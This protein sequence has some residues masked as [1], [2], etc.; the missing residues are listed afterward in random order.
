MQSASRFLFIENNA[1]KLAQEVDF[2]LGQSTIELQ[3]RFFDSTEEQLFNIIIDILNMNDNN[4]F[5]YDFTNGSPTRPVKLW[6]L[7]YKFLSL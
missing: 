4:P 5:F 2:D 7:F 1:L 3:L 6:C